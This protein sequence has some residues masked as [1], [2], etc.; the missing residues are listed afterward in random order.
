M[1]MRSSRYRGGKHL[2]ANRINITYPAWF[3]E[4]GNI[5]PTSHAGGTGIDTRILHRQDV[6]LLPSLIMSCLRVFRWNE[7]IFY[8]L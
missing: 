2:S 6:V 5:A 1:E 7:E 3:R 4:T 8:P